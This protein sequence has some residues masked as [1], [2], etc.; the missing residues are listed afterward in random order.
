[1]NM[2]APDVKT[3]DWSA[4]DIT[5][6]SHAIVAAYDHR[7][8]TA[9]TIA[10]KLSR[11]FGRTISRNSVIGV[12]NR[13]RPKAASILKDFPLKGFNY[14]LDTS[15][16]GRTRAAR[17]KVDNPPAPKEPRRIIIKPPPLGPDRIPDLR[18]TAAPEPL[19]KTLM[20]M[21]SKECRWPIDGSRAETKF[22]C[23]ET[24]DLRPYCEF[25]HRLSRGAG[26]PSERV[27]HRISKRNAA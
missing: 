25:H 26:T 6:K 12:Y 1:M 24:L 8:N 5:G 3:A 7:H 10:K 23:H 2:H 27:A 14:L 18:I 17:L 20:D 9:S 21:N 22:C 4:L 13:D 16:I 15:V 19:L 11:T